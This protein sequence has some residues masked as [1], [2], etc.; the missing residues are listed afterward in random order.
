MCRLVGTQAA[1]LQATGLSTLCQ[2]VATGRGITLLPASAVAVEARPGTGLT[3]R[4]FA[5]PAPTRTVGLVWRRSS[6]N[7]S[8]YRRLGARLA[9]TLAEM[10]ADPA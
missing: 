4:P 9:E 7:D 2:M 5:A 3:T 1:E 6:P 10:L 8:V